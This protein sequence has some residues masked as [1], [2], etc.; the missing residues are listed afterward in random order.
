M[1]EKKIYGFC[2]KTQKNVV[3]KMKNDPGDKTVVP[4]PC[5]QQCF[6]KLHRKPPGRI[7]LPKQS[8]MSRG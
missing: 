6:L 1:K 3:V 5:A 8:E 2:I 4:I 7:R